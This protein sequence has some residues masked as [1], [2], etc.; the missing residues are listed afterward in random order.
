MKENLLKKHEDIGSNPKLP[1]RRK[2]GVA[3]DAY[4]SSAV[5]E[6]VDIE[7]LGLSV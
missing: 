6:A 7:L 1:K 2:T 5:E 4:N 3:M